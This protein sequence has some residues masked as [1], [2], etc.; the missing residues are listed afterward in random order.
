MAPA[1]QL[2]TA[3]AVTSTVA[4]E[5]VL[6]LDSKRRIKELTPRA[7]ALIGRSA[8]DL[9]GR[10][11]EELGALDLMGLSAREQPV[12]RKSRRIHSIIV[13]LRL[14]DYAMGAHDELV[15]PWQ[16]SVELVVV[17]SP[18]GRI[19][20]V[21]EAFA[22]KFGIP[23]PAWSGRNPI[24]LLHPE[25]VQDWT[26]A[27]T[28]LER[29]P[30]RGSHEHRWQTA[31]GWRW[32]SWEECAV[33][34]DEGSVVAYRAVGRDVT[35]RRLAEEHYHK[36]ANAVDQSPFSIVVTTP[37]G[38]VQYVNPKF[39]Q[40]TG[41]TLEEIFE[42]EIPVLREGHASDE[43]FREFEQT[44]AAGKKWSGELCTRC[45][46]G[47]TLWE[48]VQVSP[49]RNHAD[50]ITHLLSMREDITERKKLEDQLRQAQ[51]MESLGTLAGGIAHDFNNVLAIIN[52]FTE[53]A[54]SRVG[55]D[56]TN[57]RH[58]REIH[59]AAQRAIGLVR[60]ILTFSRK[61]EATF[62]AVP[63][64][65]HIKDLGRMCAE[66]FPRTVTFS[67]DVDETIPSIWADPNQLQ[68]VIMNLCVNARDAMPDGGRIAVST[69][70]VDGGAIARL[71]GEAGRP[72]VCIK[73]S[74]TGC[75]MPA[76]VRARI[77]EPF[78]TTKQNSGGTGLGLA[79]V[80]GIILNHRG[81]LDVE[82]VEGQG[83]TFGVYLP[84]ETPKTAQGVD[85]GAGAP[86]DFPCGKETIFVV[87]DESSLRELL[88]TILEPRGYRVITA[89]DGARAVDVL[90]SE[91]GSIDVVLLDLNLPQLNG[92]DVYKTLCRLRPEAKVII[93]SGNITPDTRRELN[94]HGKPEFLPKPY[95][96]EELGRRLRT[97]LK[98]TKTASAA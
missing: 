76:H 54:I 65:Q 33:R 18:E 91:P 17:R 34:D 26:A 98:P 63:L 52:G 71:G 43:S 31:Q 72:Y 80:Y 57:A 97:V 40:S 44:V 74:D 61:T 85:A 89:S 37:D 10:P 51:K 3:L 95:Q 84:M 4:E 13:T 29:P 21:N 14:I 59:N 78:F 38:R 42:K 5:A 35:K 25:D 56:E 68:Q 69:S 6:V 48:F 50:E 1:A 2:P 66:T 30:Y 73:V 11:L 39:T 94:T 27:T 41:Y 20:A 64:N 23:R 55:A 96:I 24:T 49:I 16:N 86:S 9:L 15:A 45:K 83:S 77:F 58:L 22:R 7:A 36:L 62:K 79:V 8:V 19:L 12:Y 53:I 67:I 70:Q 82:S 32:L 92:L 87:E 90:L 75:G 88:R 47:R 28:R 60:Q 81:F 93:I 46:D